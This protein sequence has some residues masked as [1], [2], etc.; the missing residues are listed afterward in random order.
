MMNLN[1]LNA[2]LTSSGSEENVKSLLLS[3]LRVL[4]SDTS[5]PEASYNE[6]ALKL[7]HPGLLCKLFVFICKSVFYLITCV[8]IRPICM[9]SR[10]Y[11]CVPSNAAA[12]ADIP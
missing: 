3:P 2:P 12:S 9:Q 11:F 5:L 6:E 7:C 4:S 1:L 10:S 8:L